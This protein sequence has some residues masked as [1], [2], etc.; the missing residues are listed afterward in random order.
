MKNQLVLS[1]E[2]KNTYVLASLL[3]VLAVLT[4]VS[5]NASQCSGDLNFGGGCSAGRSGLII[6][7]GSGLDFGSRS[8]LAARSALIS[9][10]SASI[11]NQTCSHRHCSIRG[12]N[13]AAHVFVTGNL[14]I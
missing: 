6:D 13:P 12:C 2:A 8:G 5:N 1:L 3:H 9:L 7:D 14:A 10:D 4:V 11:V